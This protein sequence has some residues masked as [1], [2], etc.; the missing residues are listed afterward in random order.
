MDQRFHS[1]FVA[2]LAVVAMSLVAVMPTLSRLHTSTCHAHAAAIV[3]HHD[4]EQGAGD[5]SEDCWSKCGYCDFL[6]HSPGL[7][8]F[9]YVPAF[10]ALVD[11]APPSLNS[12]PLA[13]LAYALAAQPRGPPS[14]S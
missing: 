8:S 7:T 1:G 13:T 12:P 4:C 9:A 11:R 3:A 14:L 6:A 5:P 2:W 10:V